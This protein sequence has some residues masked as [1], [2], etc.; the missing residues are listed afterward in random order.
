MYLRVTVPKHAPTPAPPPRSPAYS[1]GLATVRRAIPRPPPRVPV[2]TRIAWGLCN[3]CLWGFPG[4]FVPE[5]LAQELQP[6]RGL[7]RSP[8]S[9]QNQRCGAPTPKATGTFW[10]LLP[11][12]QQLGIYLL[13]CLSALTE[14][15][16]DPL[17]PLSQCLVWGLVNRV[18]RGHLGPAV[19]S[20]GRQ[21]PPLCLH[22]AGS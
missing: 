11:R 7:P 3:S 20:K 6:G 1:L 22:K 13:T 5:A 9:W 2:P 15:S 21:P 17:G 12:A 8:S 10:S 18:R 4:K 19:H 14:D 16:W